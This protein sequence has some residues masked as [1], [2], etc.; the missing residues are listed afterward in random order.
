[1]CSVPSN[2][3]ALDD[4]LLEALNS[5][6]DRINVLRLEQEIVAF[7]Q[8]DSKDV[9]EVP[10]L[11]SYHRLLAHKTGDFYQ[12][13]HVSDTARQLILFHK[14][15]WSKLPSEQLCDIVPSKQAAHGKNRSTTPQ[16]KPRQVKIMKRVV[17][18]PSSP[19]SRLSTPASQ[20]VAEAKEK[21]KLEKEERYKAARARI[22]QGVE[23][24]SSPSTD[25]VLKYDSR[26]N[27]R[28]NS[29]DARFRSPRHKDSD[30]ADFSRHTSEPYLGDG[31]GHADLDPIQMRHQQYFQADSPINAVFQRPPVDTTKNHHGVWNPRSSIPLSMANLATLEAQTSKQLGAPAL[32]HASSPA[33]TKPN[34][35]PMRS[36]APP[37]NASGNLWGPP[38]TRSS[39]ATR[40]ASALGL[41]LSANPWTPK[42]A[43]D[44][45]ALQ[46]QSS[47]RDV[48]EDHDE[49][50]ANVLQ[51]LALDDK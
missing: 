5:S 22:F 46:E 25:K 10:S 41:N 4:N 3:L 1:M 13:T 30:A 26:S 6:K 18:T 49:D 29:R 7:L 48:L 35:P 21:D 43:I 15:P 36:L 2:A 51:G 44:H 23:E 19:P 33:I 17:D 50:P 47:R 11:N 34:T 37:T 24:S 38:A 42:H 16:S 31:M 28:S 20:T 27:S 8:N 14:H 45:G 12:L 9:L 32:A 39:L 40:N